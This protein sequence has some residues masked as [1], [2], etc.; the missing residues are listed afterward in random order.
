MTGIEVLGVDN[1]M[2]GVGD[3]EQARLF[4]EG[5][6]GLP[7]KFAFPQA[8]IVG[9]RLGPEEPGLLLRAGAVEAAT[10]RETPRVWLEVPDA[11]EAATALRGAGATVVGDVRELRTGW[12]V[13]VADAWGNVLGLTDYV[14]EPARGRLRQAH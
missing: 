1:I 10:A 9:Y 2:L 5:V 6:L 7:V 11:R 12:V 8:G 4:Y 13:E 3:L 14:K